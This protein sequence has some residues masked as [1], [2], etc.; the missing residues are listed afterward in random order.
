MMF[1]LLLCILSVFN[2]PP[3]VMSLFYRQ[4]CCKLPLNPPPAKGLK[5]KLRKLIFIPLLFFIPPCFIFFSNKSF[6][7]VIIK[8]PEAVSVSSG[9]DSKKSITMDKGDPGWIAKL[10]GRRELRSRAAAGKASLAALQLNRFRL[11]VLMGEFSDTS[12]TL[13]VQDIRE[14]LFSQTSGVSMTDY[15]AEVSY[16]QLEV[17]GDVFGWYRA[18]SRMQ[19]Y[20]PDDYASF[21]VEVLREADP[22]VDF[23]LY[24]NDGPD[25]APNSGD[26]DGYVDAVMIV[27]AG[28]GREHATSINFNSAQGELASGFVT[29]DQA[30]GGDFLKIRCLAFVSEYGYKVDSHAQTAQKNVADIG[31]A[32]HEFGH[33]LG[34][35]D[36]YDPTGET[37]GLG[38]WCMMSNGPT[39][40]A[41][42][43][44]WC[45]VM[46]G[47]VT[48]V[49]IEEKGPIQLNSVETNPEIYMLWEDGYGLGRY[50]LLEYRRNDSGFD[51]GLPGSGLL[52]Y[53]VN[54]NRWRGLGN[55]KNRIQQLPEKL[56]DLEEADGKDELDSRQS[57]GDWGDVFPGTSSNFVFDDYS[58]P[59][60]RDCQD[61]PTGIKITSI[62]HYW[63]SNN[64]GAYVKPRAMKGYSVVYD[65][66][67]IMVGWREPENWAGVLFE[68]EE[69]GYL[70]GVDI[71]S[72]SGNYDYEVRVY[73]TIS[74]TLPEGLI[75]ST[76]GHASLAGYHTVE[77][78][79]TW[80]KLEQGRQFFVVYNTSSGVWAESLSEDSG[81]SYLSTSGIGYGQLSEQDWGHATV[82]LRARI[83]TEE[84]EVLSDFNSDGLMG[85]A[86]V[87]AMMGFLHDNPGNPQADFNGD[88]S[89]DIADALSLLLAIRN[90]TL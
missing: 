17:T 37:F 19:D 13:S 89:A 14:N 73:E 49:L 25:G 51:T 32:C 87:T 55:S 68:A 86:D 47:W 83:R 22:G 42:F 80:I 20:Y 46:L 6:A 45:K 10:A 50:F 16:G 28:V 58:N 39:I 15:Y 41:H 64:I 84:I 38:N 53:H 21:A 4:D 52:I 12:G 65:N 34:L 85:P 23:S 66:M 3:H 29:D 82:N 33:V 79:D 56:V 43:S 1:I 24:D 11:P 90:G 60:S 77:F 67:G 71:G 31:V 57:L 72:P 88:G 18:D 81:R 69:G 70:A 74:D 63:A 7:A 44:A 61:N 54:E 8:N 40:R 78:N 62:R 48:P 76:T 9:R 59:N 30:H 2:A 75:Y 35:P 26:D 5:S 27:F 36:L